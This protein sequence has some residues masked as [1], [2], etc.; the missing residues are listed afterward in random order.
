MSGQDSDDLETGSQVKSAAGTPKMTTAGHEAKVPPRV[1]E[2]LQYLLG[3]LMEL[4]TTLQTLLVDLGVNTPTRLVR[5]ATD[6]TATFWMARSPRAASMAQWQALSDLR[7]ILMQ[8]ELKV[9]KGS[10]KRTNSLVMDVAQWRRVLTPAMVKDWYLTRGIEEEHRRDIEALD[11]RANL[12]KDIEQL[13]RKLSE[14]QQQAKQL[15]E[16]QSA[17]SRQEPKR[18]SPRSP[19][20]SSSGLDTDQEGSFHGAQGSGLTTPKGSTRSARSSPGQKIKHVSFDQESP[21]VSTVTGGGGDGDDGSSSSSS[22]LSSEEDS[23]SEASSIIKLERRKP[24]A[25]H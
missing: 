4:P 5:L 14:M 16:E 18:K 1:P 19:S 11:R 8:Y 10:S 23:S 12:K 6:E 13:E 25:S 2:V 20:A 21:K 22:S 15:V 7:R 24:K 17:S 9:P 3:E